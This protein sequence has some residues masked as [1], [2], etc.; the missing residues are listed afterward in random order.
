M[1][2]ID[3]VEYDHCVPVACIETKKMGAL[4]EH[5][6]TA[7]LRCLENLAAAA[8]L[9]C[10]ITR[11]VLDEQPLFHVEPRNDLAVAYLPEATYM[12]EPQYVALLTALRKEP[13]A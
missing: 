13:H 3:S 10:F 9:P 6:Y 4:A 5:T 1:T 2:D 8:K 11:Y 12:D 7:S